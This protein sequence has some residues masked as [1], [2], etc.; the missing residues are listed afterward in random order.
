MEDFKVEEL[1][2][3]SQDALLES[4]IP[5]TMESDYPLPVVDADGDLQGELSRTHLADVLSD[6]YS[7]ADSTANTDL[8]KSNLTHK[9]K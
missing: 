1:T 3:I 7:D 4:I 6:F 5:A 8:Q 9:D 2:P